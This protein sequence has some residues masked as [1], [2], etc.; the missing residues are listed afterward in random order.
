MTKATYTIRKKQQKKKKTWQHK[1]TT[2]KNFTTIAERLW[3]VSWSSDSHPKGVVKPVNGIPTFPLATKTY[4]KD[5]HLKF[6]NNN[7]YRERGPTVNPSG[8]VI[9][10]HNM[11]FKEIIIIF[12]WPAPKA[13]SLPFILNGPSLMENWCQVTYFL[14]SLGHYL[15]STYSKSEYLFLKSCILDG[16]W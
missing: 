5:A 2:K 10:G 14:S 7:P 1:H 3:T 4:Q 11:L 8:E 12:F 9:K 13:K 16:I 6:V 15:F